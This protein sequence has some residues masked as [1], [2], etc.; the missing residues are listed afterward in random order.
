MGTGFY[1][2]NHNISVNDFEKI[3]ALVLEKEIKMVLVGPEE[4]LVRGIHDYFLKD[5][6]LYDNLNDVV[7]NTN[8]LIDEVKKDPRSFFNINLFLG[9]K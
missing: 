5:D 8:S 4:P 6:S 7:E 2:E 9:G 1:A 3:K